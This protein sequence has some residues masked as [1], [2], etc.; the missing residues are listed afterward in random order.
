MQARAK[1]AIL[2]NFVRQLGLVFNGAKAV[3]EKEVGDA[4]E[5]T[6]GLDAMLFGFFNERAEDAAA[7]ALALGF[8]LDDDGAHLSEMRA[9]EMKRAAAEKDAAIGFGDGGLSYGQAAIAAAVLS[10]KS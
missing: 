9:V 2:E 6:D 8:R 1:L 3:F 10:G 5:K 7:G 4:R